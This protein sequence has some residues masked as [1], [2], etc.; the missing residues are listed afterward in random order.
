MSWGVRRR[1]VRKL[2]CGFAL[3]ATLVLTAAASAATP[4]ALWPAASEFKLPAD[5]SS[6]PNGQTAGLD[7]VAC[8]G[9]YACVTGGSYFD[10]AGFD[11]PL[12]ASE[13]LINGAPVWV[14]T[15][16]TGEALGNSTSLSSV[17]CTSQDNCTGVGFYQNGTSDYRPMTI[18]DTGGNWGQATT[19][20]LPSDAIP[21]GQD[22]AL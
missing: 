11:N 4:A 6:I 9:I 22:A 8:T 16:L 21:S 1:S 13:E 15:R 20:T 14:P 12:G 7:A 19:L 17:A 2:S 10:S 5:A 3:L 18:T